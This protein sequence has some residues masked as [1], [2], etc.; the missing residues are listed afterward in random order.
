MRKV[1]VISKPIAGSHQG[2]ASG[3]R[4]VVVRRGDL[5]MGYRFTTAGL[6][7]LETGKL[8]A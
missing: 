6:N 4:D 2:A 3:G 5:C 7:A 1:V 8:G